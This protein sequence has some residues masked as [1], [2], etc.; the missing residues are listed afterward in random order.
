MLFKM[1]L[2]FLSQV[3]VNLNM[4]ILTHFYYQLD[5]LGSPGEREPRE[6][7]CLDPV[8]LRICL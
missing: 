4:V 1:D 7:N 3:I 5:N 2:L 8:G 6:R